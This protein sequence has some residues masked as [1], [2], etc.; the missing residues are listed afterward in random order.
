MTQN[1]KDLV[2]VALKNAGSED[3][4]RWAEIVVKDGPLRQS[5]IA[6]L[7]GNALDEHNSPPAASMYVLEGEVEVGGQAPGQHTDTFVT[8]E[9]AALTHHRHWVKAKR[10]S[11]FLLTTVTSV[12]GQQSHGS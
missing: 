2:P 7:A 8:G 3:N 12:A 11:V 5:V 4:G 10:D 9:I 6:L 1:L